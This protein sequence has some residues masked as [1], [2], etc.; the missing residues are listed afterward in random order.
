MLLGN[1]VGGQ[2]PGDWRGVCVLE[3]GGSRYW[4]MEDE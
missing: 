4:E 3:Q 1:F 2:E